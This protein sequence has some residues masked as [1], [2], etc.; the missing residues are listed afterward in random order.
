MFI[1]KHKKIF[2]TLS[3]ILVLISAVFIFV[4]GLK[5]GI[6]FKGGVLLE[7]DYPAVRP[8]IVSLQT[9]IK[10]LNI[11][12]LNQVLIQPSGENEYLIKSLVLSET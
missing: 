3:I 1:I 4:F 9:A 11:S 8:D 5:P 7:A 2:L 6:D 10:T 12:N